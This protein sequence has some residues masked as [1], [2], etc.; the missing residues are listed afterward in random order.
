MTFMT[1][2][3]PEELQFYIRD[4][5]PGNVVDIDGML[6]LVTYKHGRDSSVVSLDNGAV[7]VMDDRKP[8]S[9]IYRAEMHLTEVL[10][11]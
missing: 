1:V 5:R 4:A 3:R 7:H 6:W 9:A 2:Q 8:V 11:R 10:A